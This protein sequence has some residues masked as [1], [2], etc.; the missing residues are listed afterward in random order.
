MATL[1]THHPTLAESAPAACKPVDLPAVAN[2]LR[3]GVEWP[4]DTALHGVRIHRLWAGRR[5]RV[6]LELALTLCRDERTEEL[7]LQGAMNTAAQSTRPRRQATLSPHGLLGLRLQNRAL[8][9]RCC[10]PDYDRKIPHVRRMLEARKLKKMLLEL[11]VAPDALFPARANGSAHPLETRLVA[12]RINRR[13]VVQVRSSIDQGA[14]GLFLKAFRRPLSPLRIAA[15]RRL[16]AALDVVSDHRVRTPAVMACTDDGR[17]LVTREVPRPAAP[18]G[19]SDDDFAVAAEAMA[20]LHRLKPAT[21]I[22]IHTPA[23]EL[24][25]VA[26]WINALPVACDPRHADVLSGLVTMLSTRFARLPQPEDTVIHRDFHGA[27]ILRQNGAVWIVDLDTLCVGHPELDLATFIAHQMLDR[28]QEGATADQL[29][30][31]AATVAGQY[32]ASGG[33]LD[34]A[35][36]YLYLSCALARLG[37]IHLVRGVPERTITALWAL[38]EQLLS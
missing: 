2:W 18:L 13:C 1:D 8:N 23:D 14:S 11:G 32:E 9:I 29:A 21:Y 30:Q 10:S 17:L 35:R 34:P 28:L 38:A 12:Y 20:I 7:M 31:L 4:G 24:Q 6:T 5:S 26:R 16:P 15:L 36:L 33:H 25:T 37:A 3:R 19:T 22:G 27:Q